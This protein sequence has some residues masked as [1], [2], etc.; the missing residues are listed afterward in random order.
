[1]TTTTKP[2]KPGIRER[3]RDEAAKLVARLATQR[4]ETIAKLV[5]LD[6]RL[7]G[8]RRTLA[9]YEKRIADTKPKPKRGI[10]S[11]LAQFDDKPATA[12]VVKIDDQ[13]EVPKF[14]K[15]AGDIKDKTPAELAKLKAEADAKDREAAERIREEQRAAARDK[16]TRRTRAREEKQAAAKSGETKRMPL[17]GKAA[18]AAIRG[19]NS[20]K[21]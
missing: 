11:V 9:R 7:T 21:A 4:E 17:E 18:L 6:G 8:A 3:R 5:K 10:G 15:R 13:L 16:R 1:M 19:E 12:N 20:P 2:V 14:L